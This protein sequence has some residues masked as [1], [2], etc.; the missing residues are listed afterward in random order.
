MTSASI[1]E[2]LK[3][4]LDAK[5]EVIRTEI[6][7]D[8]EVLT[9]EYYTRFHPIVPE[10]R[11]LVDALIMTAYMRKFLMIRNDALRAVAESEDWRKFLEPQR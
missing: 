2:F 3:T 4:G 10:E 7:A 5:S 1:A 9:A 8:Y 6:R 11:S